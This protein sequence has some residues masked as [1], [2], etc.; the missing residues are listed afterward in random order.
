MKAAIYTRV[1][2][3]EQ[4]SEEK[5]SL[6]LQL[7]R[8]EAY[9]KA[10]GWEVVETYEDAGFSGA[11]DVRPALSRLIRDAKAGRFEH[12]VFFKLDRFARNLKVLLNISNDLKEHGIGIASVSDS[13]DTSTPSGRAYFHM[14]GVFAEFERDII[15][16][17][18]TGGR[19]GAIK[20]RD[21]YMS[22][23]VPFGYTKTAD[24][25]L[26]IDP[27]TGPIVQRI[28]KWANEGVGLKTIAQRLNDD[29][30]AIPNPG[31]AKSANGWLHSSV[32]KILLADR[33]TGTTNYQ[34]VRK[35]KRDGKTVREKYGEPT[36]MT[37]P[38]LVTREEFDG[39]QASMTKRKRESARATKTWYMLQ[40][41]IYCRRCADNGRPDAVYE[42]RIASNGYRT[43]NCRHR[44]VYN[45]IRDHEDIRWTVDAEE[46]EQEVKVWLLELLSDPQ[47]I[48]ERVQ[49]FKDRT[50]TRSEATQEHITR[51][52][53]KLFGLQQDSDRL[54]DMEVR[55]RI[56]E[57]QADEQRARITAE[58]DQVEA[59]LDEAQADA[60]EP[61]DVRERAQALEDFL[62]GDVIK[63]FRHAPR[64]EGGFIKGM[65][66]T[67]PLRQQE[68]WKELVELLVDRVWVDDGRLTIEGTLPILDDQPSR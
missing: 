20:E 45:R 10:M 56:S 25:K 3:Q 52:R 31:K 46:V 27:V 4:A 53:T 17:R 49:L 37:C 15:N 68:G 16:D 24:R 63:R 67:W 19:H 47:A 1:S 66:A 59:E 23:L 33:Y 21:V 60:L 13:F 7:E 57:A 34:S 43:Y 11:K 61:L 64:S 54:V 2:T 8:C 32:Y 58:R 55:G 14:L 30:V 40:H 9:C 36:V 18:M 5:S 62:S 38:A 26:E 48:G 65:D 39:A 35:V 42:G 51:L 22:A 6:A 29:G 28:F 41:H 12:V 44:R 50:K